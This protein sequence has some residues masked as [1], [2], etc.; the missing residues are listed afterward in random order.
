M[1]FIP[2]WVIS[3]LKS[4]IIFILANHACGRNILIYWNNIAH[5]M[6]MIAYFSSTAISFFKYPGSIP[7]QAK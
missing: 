5:D 3:F 7:G 4:S 1:I 2:F 6:E